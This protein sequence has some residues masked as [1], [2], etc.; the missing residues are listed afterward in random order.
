MRPDKNTAF[1]TMF[2]PGKEFLDN[3]NTIPNN[4]PIASPKITPANT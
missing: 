2:F 1:V 3:A 4:E